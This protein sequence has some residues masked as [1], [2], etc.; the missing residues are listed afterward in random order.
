MSDILKDRERR[1][2]Q[3]LKVLHRIIQELEK[4]QFLGEG[5]IKI[6]KHSLGSKPY[7]V[8]PLRAEDYFTLDEILH[9]QKSIQETNRSLA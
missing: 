8:I 9:H 4:G 6:T 2:N 7:L 5:R 1:R 3:A